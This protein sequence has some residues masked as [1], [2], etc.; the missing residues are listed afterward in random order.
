MRAGRKGQISYLDLGL[1]GPSCC[2]LGGEVVGQALV[3]F[4]LG[5]GCWATVWRVV[6]VLVLE[7]WLLPVV[8]EVG[9]SGLMMLLQRKGAVE[10][11]HR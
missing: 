11:E 3:L 8:K 1:P 10:R 7:G 9:S 5:A 6:L 4:H 2:L